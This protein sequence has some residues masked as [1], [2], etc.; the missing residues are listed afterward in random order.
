MDPAVMSRVL[1]IEE[2]K[3][4]MKDVRAAAVHYGGVVHCGER[5][6]DELVI[7]STQ[8]WNEVTRGQSEAVSSSPSPYAVFA[9]AMADG[10]LGLTNAPAEQRRR[11][12]GLKTESGVSVA[13]M[14]A[15]GTEDLPPRRRPADR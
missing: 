3:Q 10:R 4:K 6:R 12:A 11:I 9:R 5:G 7:V 8:R 1:T 2:V 13:E 14:I 15:L